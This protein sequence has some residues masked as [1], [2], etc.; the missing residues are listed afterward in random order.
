M[1]AGP[2][3]GVSA[4][5]QGNGCGDTCHAHTELV[6]EV[7]WLRAAAWAKALAW[8]SLVW[9]CGE[10]ALGLWQGFA[11]GSIALVGWA[12]GSAVEGLASLIVVWR[13]TGAR[14]LSTTAERRAQKAVAVSFLL[15]APYIAVEAVR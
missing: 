14:T 6:R 11:A 8:M 10:G 15:L 7:N 5:Q 13:F 12:L 9:M 4:S 3:S 2:R 1:T